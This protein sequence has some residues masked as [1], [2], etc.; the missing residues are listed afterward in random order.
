[1][2]RIS[3]LTTHAT[4]AGSKLLLACPEEGTPKLAYPPGQGYAKNGASSSKD[5]PNAH[6]IKLNA[7]LERIT[8]IKLGEVFTIEADAAIAAGYPWRMAV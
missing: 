1:M 8:R 5:T 3:C 6:F 2:R 4:S 7:L